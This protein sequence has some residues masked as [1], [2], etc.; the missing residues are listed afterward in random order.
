MF[1]TA[2]EVTAGKKTDDEP[3]AVEKEVDEGVQVCHHCV[4]KPFGSICLV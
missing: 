4:S 2:E 3:A 1:A